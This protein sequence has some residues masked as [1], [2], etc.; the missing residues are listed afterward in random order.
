M[1]TLA[2]NAISVVKRM[3]SH[4]PDPDQAGLRIAEGDD[5]DTLSI[6]VAPSPGAGDVVLLHGGARVFV[7]ETV[8]PRLENLEL[9]AVA[10]DG[11]LQLALRENS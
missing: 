4:S 7:A 8:S 10:Q 1:L 2:M 6:E 11:A 5:D 3:T 9:Y